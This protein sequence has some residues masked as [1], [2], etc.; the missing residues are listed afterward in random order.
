MQIEALEMGLVPP[1]FLDTQV[2][3]LQNRSAWQQQFGA[4]TTRSDSAA[5]QSLQ[6]SDGRSSEGTNL[7]SS[8]EPHH[9]AAEGSGLSQAAAQD[10]RRS[11]SPLGMGGQ[12]G[13]IVGEMLY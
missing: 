8:N 5:A 4:L 9:I 3:S 10:I 6:R 11:W 12:D 13:E 2:K 1:E 7:G